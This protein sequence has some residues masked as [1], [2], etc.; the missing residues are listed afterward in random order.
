MFALAVDE[1]TGRVTA[2]YRD[3]SGSGALTA[4]QKGPS[5]AGF[6]P[7]YDLAPPTLV[8]DAYFATTARGTLFPPR[9][10]RPRACT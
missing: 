6:A 4:A 5:D 9:I 7:L 1:P 3:L 2:V 8:A 10:E